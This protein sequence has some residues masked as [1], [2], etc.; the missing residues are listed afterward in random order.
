[1]SDEYK[2]KIF[3]TTN[4][5]LTLELE[6]DIDDK[7]GEIIDDFDCESS[8]SGIVLECTAKVHFPSGS[9]N[10]ISIKNDILYFDDDLL[11]KIY[12]LGHDT[13]EVVNTCYTNTDNCDVKGG[14]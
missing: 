13:I 14:G 5:R 10:N 4:K 3:I 2:L 12:E 1:M 7:I 9:P 11:H 8:T 6:S